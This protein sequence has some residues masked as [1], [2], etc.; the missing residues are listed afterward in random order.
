MASVVRQGGVNTLVIESLQLEYGG[1]LDELYM[2]ASINK[3]RG[4][5]VYDAGY[6]VLK[7]T[8]P[9]MPQLPVMTGR[10]VNLDIAAIEALQL[11]AGEPMDEVVLK[12]A[13]QFEAYADLKQDESGTGLK[14]YFHGNYGR[15][16][17][18]TGFDHDCGDAR[19]HSSWLQC[20][21]SK[22]KDDRDTRQAVINLWR[23]END[24]AVS[25][26]SDYPCTVAIGF[27]MYRGRLDMHVT[28]RSNDAWKGLPYDVFQFNQAH[29]TVANMLSVSMG[30]Y[31]HNAWS[32][33]VYDEDAA[34]LGKVHNRETY[35]PV[36]LPRGFTHVNDAVDI[37]NGVTTLRYGAPESHAWYARRLDKF[38]NDEDETERDEK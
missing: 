29:W 13:P 1:V 20:A 31:Y 35:A 18:T 16:M 25:G 23:N 17:R 3:P 9:M 15:R 14:H 22:I 34:K 27:R 21:V 2:S 26:R 11:I 36:A 28:M 10:G 5:K 7:I 24:N 4:Q 19:W 37:A 38:I 6:T 8:Q 33:H 32:M 30:S 12:I